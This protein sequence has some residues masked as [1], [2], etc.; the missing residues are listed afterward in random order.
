M[1]NLSKLCFLLV[2]FIIDL[3]KTYAYSAIKII[4]IINYNQ[5]MFSEEDTTKDFI[6]NFINIVNAQFYFNG[7]EIEKVQGNWFF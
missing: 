3:H 2:F 4:M 7:L 6:R 5:R 1:K